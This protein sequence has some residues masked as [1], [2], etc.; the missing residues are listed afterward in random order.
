MSQ[1]AVSRHSLERKLLPALVIFVL[2]AIVSLGL[3]FFALSIQS[4]VRG[5]VAGEGIWSKKQRDAIF[6]LHLY[7]QTRDPRHL[8]NFRANIAVPLGDG[9]ARIELLKPDFDYQ[10]A[11]QGFLQGQNHPED[12]PGMIR[13]LRCCAELPHVKRALYYWSLGDIHLAELQDIATDLQGEINASTPSKSRIDQLLAELQKLNYSVQPLEAAFTETLSDAARWITRMLFYIT[14]TIIAVLLVLGAYVS[15]RIV[16]GVRQS[17]D[18]YRVL[19]NTANDALFVVD[20]ERGTILETNNMA[21]RVT[22]RSPSTLI[23]TD[24]AALFDDVANDP[25]ALFGPGEQAPQVSRHRVRRAQGAPVPVEVSYSV[26]QWEERPAHLAIVRDISGQVQSERALRVAANAMENMAE[27]VIISD[28]DRNVVS[29]NQAYTAITGYSEAEVIGQMPLYPL[30]RLSDASLHASIWQAV[31]DSGRWQGEIWN[32]RKNG[33]MYPAWLSISAVRDVD[34]AIGHY[35][36]VFNDI[37]SY[38]EY[39]KRLQHLAHFD[40][41]TQLL[42]RVAFEQHCR[43]AL[44]RAEKKQSTGALLFIDLDSFKVVNDSYGHAAG[45]ELLRIVAKRIRTCVRDQDVVGRMGG[46]EFTVLL[47]DLTSPH[48]ATAVARKLL[49]ALAE[50]MLCN[51]YE[52]SISGSIGISIFPRDASDVQTL[53][54]RA[55]TAMYRAKENGRNNYQVFSPT[56]AADV[57]SRLALETSLKLAIERRQFELFYQPCVELGSGRVNGVEALIRWRHPERGL[58]PPS[59]FINLAEEIGIMDALTKWVLQTACTQGAVWRRRGM[60]GVVIAVNISPRSFW[61]PHFSA[62]V[63]RILDETGW[64]ANQLCLEITENALMN[65]DEPRKVLDE[66]RTMGVEIAIDDFGIGYSSLNYLK[67]FSIHRLKIDRSFTSGVPQDPSNIAISRAIIA[68]AKSLN[69][70]VI[71][72]GIETPEQRDFF[73]REG[74]DDGQGYLFS[75]PAPPEEIECLLLAKPT[76][77]ASSPSA[78]EG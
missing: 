9:I 37:S 23:G 78:R 77:I 59:E 2:I 62:D 58:L 43:A 32:R 19:L 12:I 56:L 69:L 33:E 46:D 47:E 63:G 41:L 26:T 52:T 35:I 31:A 8:E 67:H 72:E 74:C 14:S 15:Q 28:A 13:L 51:G 60:T 24:Y 54:T 44:E 45:D 71:A 17:E 34:G 66:L 1:Y 49:P 16:K 10:V 61:D 40:A 25:G 29:V 68:L 21:E 48:D 64:S 65:G 18:Q 55:D 11:Q 75:K 53:L 27:G 70:R 20:R 57:R 36:G 30:S 42:N 76:A 39:E 22:G 6:E 73:A 5:F 38:K 7:A 50:R 4:S 3:T